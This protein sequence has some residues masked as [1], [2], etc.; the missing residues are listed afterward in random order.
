MILPKCKCS[1][2]AYKGG[3]PVG[4]EPGVSMTLQDT[5]CHFVQVTRL[6]CLFHLQNEG[7]SYNDSFQFNGEQLDGEL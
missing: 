1:E 5:P 2:C 6:K 7:E 3:K 4:Q